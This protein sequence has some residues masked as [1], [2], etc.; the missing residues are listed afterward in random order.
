[1]AWPQ[2]AKPLM[3]LVETTS[4]S[5]SPPFWRAA[6]SVSRI[7]SDEPYA[8]DVDGGRVGVAA[9]VVGLQDRPQA[10][11]LGRRR[12]IGRAAIGG[13]GLGEAVV[14]AILDVVDHVLKLHGH[15]EVERR[16]DAARHD[17]CPGRLGRAADLH[18]E[19]E[20][21]AILRARDADRR[22]AGLVDLGAVAAVADQVDGRAVGDARKRRR[23]GRAA[24]DVERSSSS[25]GRR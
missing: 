10:V 16:L 17:L 22:Q 25:S 13:R 14:A 4:R 2:V 12:R 7:R 8:D 21:L 20:R 24:N 23:A 3:K 1:M 6:W 11:H 15:V 5:G 18:R 9:D 19:L